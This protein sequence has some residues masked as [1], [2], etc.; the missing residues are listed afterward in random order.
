MGLSRRD[1]MK[2]A[3]MLAAATGFGGLALS[4]GASASRTDGR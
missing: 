1:L 4:V 3:G 2:N